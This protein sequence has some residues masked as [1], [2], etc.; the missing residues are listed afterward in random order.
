MTQKERERLIMLA[1]VKKKEISLRQA[2]RVL[3]LSYRQ[4]KRVWRRFR[5]EG[6]AGLVHRLRDKPSPRGRESE[7]RERVLARYE[8]QYPDFGPTLAAEHLAREGLKLDHETLR[9]WLLA[10]GFWSVQ[11]SR[12]KHRQWRERRECVGEMVQMDGSEH[13]WFEGRRERAVLMVL[14]DDATNRTYARFFEGETTQAAFVS[15]DRYS[16][17]HGVPESLYVDR[18]S[19]YRTDREPTLAEQMAGEKPKTQFGRAMEKLGVK[20]ILAYSPQA[21]GRVERRNGVFQDRLV[22]E[23]RLQ[24]IAD[25]ESANAFL[26]KEFLPALNRKFTVEAR[27]KSDLHGARPKNMKEILA[28]EQTRVVGQDWTVRVEGEWLQIDRRHEGLSLAGKEIVVRDRI[29]GK[30]ELVYRAEKLRWKRLPAR[31]E[32][33]EKAVRDKIKATVQ[34]PAPEHPWRRFGM[35]TG[36]P[37]W[38]EQKRAGV[39]RKGFA[40]DSVAPSLRSGSTTSAA[41]R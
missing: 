25:L 33:K 1:R 20:I 24:G 7:F 5:I 35:G 4:A 6:D 13:D 40:A 16:R 3:G 30:R 34:P 17:R 12:Q 18:D 8:K 14:I 15:F 41:K 37:F 21:K 19:I 2:S 39:R 26:E 27:G 38:K 9:R 23:M 28:C 10:K 31:P 22:K 32:K 11:R 36:Q 29:D